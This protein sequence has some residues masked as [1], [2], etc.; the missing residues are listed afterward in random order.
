M[1]FRWKFLASTAADQAKKCKIS[2]GNRQTFK[3]QRKNELPLLFFIFFQIE[4]WQGRPGEEIWLVFL[5]SVKVR[6]CT[7]RLICVLV[8]P[9]KKASYLP[10][11]R[12]IQNRGIWTRTAFCVFKLWH[13]EHQ[14]HTSCASLNSSF[15]MLSS[16]R[17]TEGRISQN[18]V[19]AVG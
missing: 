15:V 13:R 16:S 11:S 3:T 5:W 17:N 2:K 10:S 6:S 14:Y 1:A 9:L 8:L 4:I 7:D 12:C 19:V 18:L